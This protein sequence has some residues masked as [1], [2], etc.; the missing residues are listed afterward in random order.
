MGRARKPE[1]CSAAAHASGRVQLS[2]AQEHRKH[3]KLARPVR[4]CTPT[5]RTPLLALPGSSTEKM[6]AKLW[7][8]SGSVTWDQWLAHARL[9]NDTVLDR[10][11]WRRRS[12]RSCVLW[13]A[14]QNAPTRRAP[15]PGGACVPSSTIPQRSAARCRQSGSRCGAAAP[16]TARRG[17]RCGGGVSLR[18][19]RAPLLHAAAA[20]QHGLLARRCLH[21][22]L[23]SIDGMP[24]GS[25]APLLAAWR[26]CRDRSGVQGPYARCQWLRNGALQMPMLQ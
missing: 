11:S 17:P 20:L 12:T 15:A 4:T 24:L 22:R 6:S 16:R 19:G 23:P 14:G 1:G 18:A 26:G 13:F 8:L 9:N 21:K 3:R 7:P 2:S 10:D 5:P 25:L